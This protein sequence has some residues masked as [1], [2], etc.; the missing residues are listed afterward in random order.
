MRRPISSTQSDNSLNRAAYIFARKNRGLLL[1]VTIFL[2]NVFLMRLLVGL[3][4][5][6]FRQASAGDVFAK[7]GLLLFYLGRLVLPS[8]GAV[9]KRWHFHHRLKRL[10]EE[11]NKWGWLPFGC[12]FL[13]AAYPI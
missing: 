3:F 13:P 5:D 8:V 10:R 7:T 2:A 1:D 11:E 12:I 9:L 6:I 4:L